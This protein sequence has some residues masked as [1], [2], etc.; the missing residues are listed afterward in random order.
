MLALARRTISDSVRPVSE[1]SPVVLSNCDSSSLIERFVLRTV[2]RWYLRVSFGA[3]GMVL[4]SSP[5][6]YDFGV[7]ICW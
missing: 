6:W 7:Q 4:T 5:T 2:F 3:S 1:V